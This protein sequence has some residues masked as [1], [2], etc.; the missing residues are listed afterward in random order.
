M[1]NEEI[2]LLAK[3]C[4]HQKEAFMQLLDQ[5]D[6]YSDIER[7]RTNAMLQLYTEQVPRDPEPGAI[8]RRIYMYVEITRGTSPKN[9]VIGEL[10]RVNPK[11]NYQFDARNIRGHSPEQKVTATLRILGYGLP[12][13]ACDEYVRMAKTTAYDNLKMFCET[14]VNHFG[15]NFLRYPT[16]DDVN[17]LLDENRA[18]CFPGML[19]SLDCVHWVWHECLYA[20]QGQYKGYYIKPIVVLEVA[21]SYDCWIWHGFFG[22]PGC[23]NDINILHKSPLFEE[24]KYGKA[25]A[26]TFT[27]NDNH[28]NMRYFLADG[29]Y[30]QWSTL[31]QAYDEIPT[32]GN[33]SVLNSCLTTKKK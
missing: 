28:Y 16:Q 13:D 19:G 1:D 25:P 12:A 7:S 21:A 31:V 26:A 15:P 5:M 20:W 24:L 4:F 33:M 11:I 17:R 2:Q 10:C 29:I 3:T 6:A 9:A 22:L 14:V 8:L 27:I 23:N 32:N 18:I 30:P